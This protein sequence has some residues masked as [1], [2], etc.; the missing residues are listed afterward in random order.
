[1][2]VT[3]PNIPLPFEIPLLIHPL[4]VHFAIAIPVVI[5]ILELVNLIV[6][7]KSIGGISFFLMV[8]TAVILFGSYLTGTADA[9]SAKDL[10]TPEAKE[11]LAEHKQFGIYLVY[12][13]L[14]LV[15]VKLITS[16][17][18][19]IQVKFIF[20]LLMIGFIGLTFM[21]GKE[22]GELVYEHGVNIQKAQKATESEKSKPAVESKKEETKTQETKPA[23]AEENSSQ[24]TEAPKAE[25]KS[26]AT[27]N[28][29]ATKVES[30]SKSEDSATDSQTQESN[31]TE[32][33]NSTIVVAE[34]KE[35]NATQTESNTTQEQNSTK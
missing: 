6:R 7:R 34:K 17:I 24:T 30:K 20:L 15:G 35:V 3:I 25:N 29:E 2:D 31:K 26:E 19:K 28:T 13:S 23:T 33:K 11:T 16:I 14:G 5:L 21:T 4:L 18:N 32:D 27:A 1:M 9:T 8:L 12:L 22:G 10:L